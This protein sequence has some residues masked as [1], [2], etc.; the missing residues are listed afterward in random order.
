[1][2]EV[3]KL[4]QY[5]RS[6]LLEIFVVPHTNGM[7]SDSDDEYYEGSKKRR[8]TG[9][10]NEEPS[11]PRVTRGASAKSKSD[12]DFVS[13]NAMPPLPPLLSDTN[14]S[15]SFSNN[16]NASSTDLQQRHYP[17]R[18]GFRCSFCNHIRNSTSKA[19]KAS[20]F[21]LRLHNIYREVCAWQRI[22]FKQCEFVPVGVTER[23][24]FL[25]ESDTSRGKVR[26]WES[27]AMSIGLSDNPERYVLLFVLCITMS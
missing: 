7:D 26:Y 16:T 19:S 12:H 3:N 27:S 18:V 14:T 10:K 1:V 2:D 21:P 23:Y 9:K 6:D 11:T 22:H 13:Y 8:K 20:F 25:K 24:N 15:F 4:H 5:V 17:G